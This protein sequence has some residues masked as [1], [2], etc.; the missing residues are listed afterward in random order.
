MED[1][2]SGRGFR[3]FAQTEGHMFATVD[4]AFEGEDAGSG[5]EPVGKAQGHHHLGANR[6]CGWLQHPENSLTAS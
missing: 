3:A 5:R 6:G 2:L 1:H 4:E